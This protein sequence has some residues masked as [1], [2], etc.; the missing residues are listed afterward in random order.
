MP[1]RGRIYYLPLTGDETEPR[2][3]RA[4]C[5]RPHSLR[6]AGWPQSVGC[7][8]GAP[9]LPPADPA[10]VP[11]HLLR[12]HRE[13][14]LVWHLVAEKQSHLE[15]FGADRGVRPDATIS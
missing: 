9:C 7:C 11:A 5:P 13:R 6:V 12:K 8:H 10:S 4:V 2:R 15:G 14:P 1:A 3:D